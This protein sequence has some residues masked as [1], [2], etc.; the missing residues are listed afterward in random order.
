MTPTAIQLAQLVGPTLAGELIADALRFV[1]DKNGT[2]VEVVIGALHA[3]HP[4]ASRQFAAVMDWTMTGARDAVAA[5]A[6]TNTAA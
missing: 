1:A 6:A 4:G 5:L 2:T 3:N